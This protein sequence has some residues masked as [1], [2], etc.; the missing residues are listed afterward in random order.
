MT[1]P[2]DP[3]RQ[4]LQRLEKEHTPI[5]YQTYLASRYICATAHTALPIPTAHLSAV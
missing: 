3:Q 1:P 4:R 2:S 5:I